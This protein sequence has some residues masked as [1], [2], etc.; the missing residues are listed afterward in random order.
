MTVET[1]PRTERGD[2]QLSRELKGYLDDKDITCRFSDR[3]ISCYRLDLVH[4]LEFCQEFGGITNTSQLTPDLI[5]H[6]KEQMQSIGYKTRTVTRKI[7]C[8]RGFVNWESKRGNL[9]RDFC[10]KISATR[11]PKI[12]SRILTP[13]ETRRVTSAIREENGLWGLRNAL[14]AKLA[15][16]STMRVEQIVALKIGDI[17]IHTDNETVDIQVSGDRGKPKT[18]YLDPETS[19]LAINYWHERSYWFMRK[20]MSINPDDL[21]FI[22]REGGPLTRQGFWVITTSFGKSIDI[23]DLTPMVLR[24]TGSRYPQLV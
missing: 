16:K 19:R 3:T 20:R 15:L 4:F 24:H 18:I 22:N 8:L 13:I 9:D 12:T 23:P 14:L 5:E 1:S 10:D 7:A 17:Y 6:W 2:S 21:F 11:V